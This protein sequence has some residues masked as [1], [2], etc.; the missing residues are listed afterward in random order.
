MV[1]FD[2]MHAFL[3]SLEHGS[4]AIIGK[5]SQAVES[6]EAVIRES[7]KTGLVGV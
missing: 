1:K 2:Q 4:A 3:V 7:L 6:M 5:Q